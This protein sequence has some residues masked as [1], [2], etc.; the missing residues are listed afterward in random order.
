MKKLIYIA[1]AIL[2]VVGAMSCTAKKYVV[3]EN[4]MSVAEPKFGIDGTM[5]DT[6]IECYV[7]DEL[8]DIVC[9]DRIPTHSKSD[10]VLLPKNTSKVKIS[11]N[12]VPKSTYDK[13]G[14]DY[15]LYRRTIVGSK[16]TNDRL[17]II[18]VDNNTMTK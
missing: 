12:G 14:L 2:V 5:F 7:G 18:M 16:F 11:F 17:T 6:Y 3:I 1:F 8:A 15:G 4:N 9:V 13:Y 10:K